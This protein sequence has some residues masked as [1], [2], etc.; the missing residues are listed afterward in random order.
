[1]SVRNDLDRNNI[2]LQHKQNLADLKR[3]NAQELDHMKLAHVRLKNQVQMANKLEINSLHHQHDLDLAEKAHKNEKA[4]AKMQDSLNQVKV[5][6]AKEKEKIV[7][8][9]ETDLLKLKA[10]YD[11]KAGMRRDKHAMLLEDMDHQASIKLNSIQRQIKSNQ[12][13][14]RRNAQHDENLIKHKSNLNKQIDK[15]IYEKKRLAEND[16][17]QTALLKQKTQNNQ[18]LVHTERQ[19][20]KKVLTREKIY[21]DQVEKLNN[22]YLTQQ[23]KLQKSHEQKYQE[24]FQR[25]NR[26][27]QTLVGKK[28]KIISHLRQLLRKEAKKE[29]DLN[30]DSFYHSF[31]LNPKIAKNKTNDGYLVEIQIPEREAKNV[32]LTG[33]NRELRLTFNRDF[34]FQKQDEDGSRDQMSKVESYTSKIP[35]E[36]IIDAKSIKESYHEGKLTFEIKFA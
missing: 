23:E 29:M 20:Q 13:Q 19:H 27:L 33:Q 4:L 21:N 8:Q 7:N 34:K 14:M 15:E 18:H 22:T 32:K 16:K 9:H 25:N 26:Q 2:R 1:M 5:H 12:D 6:T 28:D 31:D 30:K 35:V 3:Q 24:N 36:Y 17:Y 10:D 11:S